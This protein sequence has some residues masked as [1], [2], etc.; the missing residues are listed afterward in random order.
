MSQ[1]F[2]EMLGIPWKIGWGVETHISSIFWELFACC[3]VVGSFSL[4]F[5]NILGQ[6]R[7][8]S[9]QCNCFSIHNFFFSVQ[10]LLNSEL[11]IHCAFTFQFRTFSSGCN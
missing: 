1:K 11:F 9:S 4:L 10:F 5:L 8:F 7:T 3:Q 6:F 2:L